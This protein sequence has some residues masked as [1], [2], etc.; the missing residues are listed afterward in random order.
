MMQSVSRK[1][2][3][4]RSLEMVGRRGCKKDWGLDRSRWGQER[5]QFLNRDRPPL[6]G[7]AEG[8]LPALTPQD[9]DPH[10]LCLCAGF[11]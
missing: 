6:T 9:R 4:Y 1:G 7:L 10:P 3:L 5:W 2:S 11:C 8:R